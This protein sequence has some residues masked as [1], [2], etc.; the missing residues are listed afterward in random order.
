MK[1]YQIHYNKRKII[2]LDK[3]D[4]DVYKVN[5]TTQYDAYDID[6]LQQY[7]PLYSLFFQLNSSNFNNISLNHMNHIVNLHEVINDE[8]LVSK[9]E[10]FIKFAPYY[11]DN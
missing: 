1:K 11:E 10:I 8:Q 2:T 6:S 3:F 9:K 5:S 4:R 7:N